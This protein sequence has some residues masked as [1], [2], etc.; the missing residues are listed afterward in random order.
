MYLRTR[1]KAQAGMRAYWEENSSAR[2]VKRLYRL[3]LQNKDVPPRE[4]A[5][6]ISEG[7]GDLTPTQVRR[8]LKKLRNEQK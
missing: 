7:L 8:I 5:R 6:K 4:I 1:K 2:E 3:Y